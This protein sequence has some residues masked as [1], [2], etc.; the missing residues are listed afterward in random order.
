VVRFDWRAG[1][2][3]I[4]LLLATLLKIVDIF[5]NILVPTPTIT[6]NHQEQV[7]YEWKYGQIV[8][9]DNDDV[10]VGPSN[11]EQADSLRPRKTTSECTG[12]SRE[13][14]TLGFE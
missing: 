14:Q 7:D 4:C 1:L 13:Q 11:D 3:Q 9:L 12:S 2:G 10:A 8:E 5:I 6:R